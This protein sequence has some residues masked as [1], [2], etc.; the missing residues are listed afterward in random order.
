MASKTTAIK[1]IVGWLGYA[2]LRVCDGC[3]DGL[4]TGHPLARNEAITWGFAHPISC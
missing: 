3:K 1:C 2:M 4:D